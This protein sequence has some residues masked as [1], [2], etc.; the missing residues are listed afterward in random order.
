MGRRVDGKH[1]RGFVDGVWGLRV[2]VQVGSG[3]GR[4]DRVKGCDITGVLSANCHDGRSLSLRC[5]P[6]FCGVTGL[7]CNAC[8]SPWTTSATGGLPRRRLW[9]WPLPAPLDT[10]ARAKPVPARRIWFLACVLKELQEQGRL[11]SVAPPATKGDR[12]G[13]RRAVQG[14]TYQGSRPVPPR[15]QVQRTSHPPSMSG[16]V[17]SR[18]CEASVRGWIDGR[19]LWSGR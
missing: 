12:R 3:L 9:P 13:V 1:G 7:S 6:C 8:V 17:L 5:G 16:E 15:L 18:V 11:H 14:V 19:G 2:W 10:A 4:V